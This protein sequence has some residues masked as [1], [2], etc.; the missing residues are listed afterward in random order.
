MRTLALDSM[1]GGLGDIWMRLSA[2]YSLTAL[3]PGI[4]VSLR[5]PEHLLATAR[6]AFPDRFQV[7]TN[8]VERAHR[9]SHLGLRHLIPNV[10]RGERYICPFTRI[11]QTERKRTKLK[12]LINDALFSIASVTARIKQPPVSTVQTYQG[13]HELSALMQLRVSYADFIAQAKKDLPEI[14]KRLHLRW[15]ARGEPGFD[16]LAFPGGSAHQIMPP[17]WAHSHIPKVM[18]AFYSNDPFRLAYEALGLKT[19]SFISVE[20]LIVLA[21]SARR[22]LMTDSFPSH[23]VQSYTN[24]ATLMLTEQVPPR[25]IHPGFEGQVIQSAAPCAPCRHIVRG[26]SRCQAGHEYCITWSALSHN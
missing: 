22:I 12:D 13:F 8:S 15:P 21:A 14:R 17:T 16:V 6:T 25:T 26:L 4:S 20:E 24:S 5:I 2:L 11:L 18:F 19:Q 3:R 10:L 1:V 23:I 7:G 9:F